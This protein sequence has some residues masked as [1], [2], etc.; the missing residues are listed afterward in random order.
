MFKLQF[1]LDKIVAGCKITVFGVSTTA[2][3]Q[4]RVC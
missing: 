2:K 1:N 3:E 4:Q